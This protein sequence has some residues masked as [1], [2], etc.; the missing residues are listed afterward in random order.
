MSKW[1]PEPYDENP[2]VNAILNVAC[3]LH[4]L[5]AATRSLLYGLKYGEDNGLSI[6]EAI[7]VGCNNIGSTLADA[8]VNHADQKD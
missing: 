8:I 3:G 7:E 5:A 2:T 1:E 4:R 6:A